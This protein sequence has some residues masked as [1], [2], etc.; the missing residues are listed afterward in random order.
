MDELIRR[1]YI[2]GPQGPR[3]PQGPQGPKGEQGPIGLKGDKGDMG[4]MGPRGFQGPKGDPFTYEDF[5]EEQLEGLKTP[6]YIAAN[7]ADAKVAQ[8]ERQEQA[9]VE[10]Y[11]G[12]KADV[13]EAT[14]NANNAATLANQ[15]AQLAEDNI[16]LS[17]AATTLATQKAGLAQD[18]ADLAQQKAELADQKATLADQK[19]ELADAAAQNASEK[20]A[21]AAN[22]NAILNGTSITVTDRDGN[23][24][25]T[26]LKGDKGDTGE[27]FT[28]YEEYASTTLMNADKDNVP[29]GSFVIINSNAEDPDNSKLYIRTNNLTDYPT[30]FKFL[31]DMSGAQGIQ[32]QDGSDGAPGQDGHTPVITASKSNGVTT[33]SVDG[34]AIATINDGQ[35]GQNGQDGQDAVSPTLAT[36]ATSG[37]YNDLSNKPS[38]PS[39][40][41]DLTNDSNFIDGLVILSYGSSTWNDFINAYNKNKVVYCR[42]SSNSNP[43]TG[44]QT[45][46]AFMAYVSNSTS[47]TSVEFQYYRSVSSHADNQ[48]GDQIFVYK[49]TNANAWS[50]EVRE[51]YTKVV[52][53]TGLSSSYSNGAITLTNGVTE[54]TV[55]GWGFTKS[56]GTSTFSGSYNDLTDK[57][58]IPNMEQLE[59]AIAAAIS[60]LEERVTLL[61]NQNS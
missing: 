7:E 51:A 48:Q 2:Q 35:D 28:I 52:A 5:T 29:V 34:A 41:S 16:A 43:G 18:K 15:K 12:L 22:V 14:D 19:A 55:S 1:S 21:E 37:S 42:A 9:R 49:L 23:S 13:L 53:G 20:A 8:I 56:T 38:I 57:P 40:T 60:S 59:L 4:P 6:V 31:T 33:I 44:S 45:R 17:E 46:L 3:G 30:G 26:N 27:G 25:T 11:A 54:S 32:G 36:V 47:P 39:K 61:E 58:E 50:V 10:E 24:I